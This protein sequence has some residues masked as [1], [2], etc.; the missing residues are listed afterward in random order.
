MSYIMVVYSSEQINASDLFACVPYLPFEGSVKFIKSWKVTILTAGNAQA[1]FEIYP[2]P[3]LDPILYEDLRL[4]DF[5]KIQTKI[6]MLFFPRNNRSKYIG[7]SLVRELM[8]KYHCVLELPDESQLEDEGND[9]FNLENIDWLLD[10][11][12]RPD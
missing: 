10:Y 12:Q 9:E 11:F 8:K 4:I 5:K 7:V 2:S 1:N 3:N 6:D